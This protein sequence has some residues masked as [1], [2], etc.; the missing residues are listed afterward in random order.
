MMKQL[1]IFC[2]VLFVGTGLYAT[3]DLLRYDAQKVSSTFSKLD[4]LEQMHYAQP[5][6]SLEDLKAQG[7]FDG[8]AIESGSMSLLAPGDGPPL[9]P[10]FW[11]GCILG[12]VGILIV[13]LTTESRD[14]TV[15][16]VYGCITWVVVWGVF[17]VLGVF[18]FGWW[19]R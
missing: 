3:D 6:A 9:V 18:A 19:A 8:M 13:Y 14:Q 7:N 10:A 4:Q 17:Y 12:V 2:L 5:N 15:K 1:I 11:W 16:A